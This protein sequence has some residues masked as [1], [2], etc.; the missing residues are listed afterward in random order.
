MNLFACEIY[1]MLELG[2]R[3]DVVE[4]LQTVQVT[5]ARAKQESGGDARL[6]LINCRIC[7]F[8][9]VLPFCERLLWLVPV[10]LPALKCASWGET[11]KMLTNFIFNL[12]FSCWACRS[13]VF[14]NFLASFMETYWGRIRQLSASSPFCCHYPQATPRLMAGQP[15]RN[16]PCSKI[17]RWLCSNQAIITWPPLPKPATPPPVPSLHSCIQLKGSRNTAAMICVTQEAGFW[18]L[19]SCQCL[20]WPFSNP[21]HFSALSSCAEMQIQLP[22]SGSTAAF[23]VPPSRRFPLPD[24]F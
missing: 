3:R 8:P 20:L 5:S 7:D 18:L 23:P 2:W 15:A 13:S 1:N 17:K 16:R 11:G 9:G 21:P 4:C 24:S 10:S 12:S 22:V 19:W 14:W 6:L